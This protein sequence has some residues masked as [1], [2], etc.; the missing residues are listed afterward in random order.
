MSEATACAGG[1]APSH[2]QQRTA[3]R[4]E[5]LEIPLARQR[6]E[7]PQAR[8]ARE[9]AR[10]DRR[11]H[12]RQQRNPVLRVGDRECADRRQEEEV[13]TGHAG[14]RREG[15]LEDPPRRGEGQ[16]DDEVGERDGRGVDGEDRDEDE[17]HE[18]DGRDRHR[19]THR[20]AERRRHVA[21]C[22]GEA[23][24]C[25]AGQRRPAHM[26]A[27][28]HTTRVASTTAVATS[29]APRPATRR[30]PSGTCSG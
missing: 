28:V 7:R 29:D 9:L 22:I 20:G 25:P 8:A 30:E 27:S 26:S 12:E 13:Q 4:V 10:D 18:P 15:S 21:E 5:L 1:D 14:E 19:R 23:G 24:G 2:K 11:R 3:Q 16:N 17:R 6:F